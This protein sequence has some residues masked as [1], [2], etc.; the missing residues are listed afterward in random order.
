M[1]N[2]VR[3]QR[4]QPTRLLRP[5][6]SLGKNTEVGCHFLLQV[7][8]HQGPNPRAHPS[9]PPKLRV[10][11]AGSACSLPQTQQRAG[12]QAEENVRPEA[13]VHIPP[14]DLH[15]VHS[16]AGKGGGVTQYNKPG[17][18]N[19]AQFTSH[20]CTSQLVKTRKLEEY[21]LILR[22]AE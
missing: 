12:H 4:Q 21:F 8:T 18:A 7:S 3:P 14:S 13:W 19:H 20:F 15:T 17:F 1:S 9:A 10:H 6:D 2:S 11:S 5:Q 22:E 16:V